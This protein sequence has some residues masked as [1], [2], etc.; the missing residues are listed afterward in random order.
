MGFVCRLFG[1]K[2][3]N[4][5][6]IRCGYA[7]MFHEWRDVPGKCQQ[8]CQIC[9]AVWETN[10]SYKEVTPCIKVCTV[11][12]HKEFPH[13]WTGEGCAKICSVCGATKEQH[14]WNQVV[15]PQ[16]VPHP[17]LVLNGCKCNVCGAI[18]PNGE[19][20]FE[21]EKA[22]GCDIEKCTVCGY[23]KPNQPPDEAEKT[24]NE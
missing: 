8:I 5:I 24:Q 18:N 13:D 23:V 14:Q 20:Q 7:H 16:A 9:G 22:N 6:C 1:H 3:E 12:G 17:D 19:H 2:L 10:H 11:C 15:Y 4:N 21:I